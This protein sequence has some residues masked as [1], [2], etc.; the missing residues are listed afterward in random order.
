MKLLLIRHAESLGNRKQTM[1]G[2]LDDPLSPHGVLQSQILAQYLSK[3]WLPTHLYSSP[4]SRAL[5]TSELLMACHTNLEVPLTLQTVDALVEIHNGIFQGLTWA[6]AEQQYPQLCQQLMSR[7]DWIPI[8]EGETWQA[9]RDRAQDF[10]CTLYQSHDN[11]DRIWIISHGGIL[12]YLIA[13]I[14]GTPMIWGLSI[15][16]TALFEFELE[17]GPPSPEAPQMCRILRFN[18]RPHLQFGEHNKDSLED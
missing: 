15:Q 11:T 18:E 7:T 4:L 5:A 12:Q 6:E 13:A 1:S 2:Q 16:N 14:L 8:P 10:V 17:V 9:C 3:Y